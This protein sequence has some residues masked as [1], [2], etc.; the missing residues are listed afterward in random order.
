MFIPNLISANSGGVIALANRIV[1]V[2]DEPRA[3]LD[4]AAGVQILDLFRD[5]AKS[6]NKGLII[7][8]HDPKVRRVA[9][10]VEGIADGLILPEAHAA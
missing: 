9:D 10:R 2:E 8:T 1:I 5:L 7:V 3:N 6:E 4:S